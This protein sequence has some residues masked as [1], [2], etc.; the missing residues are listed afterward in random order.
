[1]HITSDVDE[2]YYIVGLSHF[3]GSFCGTTFPSIYTRISYFIEWI[4]AI[5][6]P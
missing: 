4:E 1:M 3:A 2:K 5:V 6:W